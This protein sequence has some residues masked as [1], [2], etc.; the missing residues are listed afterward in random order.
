MFTPQKGFPRILY[1]THVDDKRQRSGLLT[2][3]LKKYSADY[4]SQYVA[5][6]HAK[7][8]LDA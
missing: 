6:S 1:K 4:I 2:S 5:S 7:R 3:F 8:M